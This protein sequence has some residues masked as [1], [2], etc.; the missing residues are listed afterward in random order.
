MHRAI[1]TPRWLLCAVVCTFAPVAGFA[2]ETEK[3]AP[4]TP[5][6]EAPAAIETITAEDLEKH[7]KIVASDAFGGRGTGTEG[8]AKAAAYIAKHFEACGLEPMGDEGEDGKRGWLQK[9]PITLK[10]PTEE[11]GFRN[12]EGELIHQR[13]GWLLS[14]AMS[15]GRGKLD[16]KAPVR[17]LDRARSLEGEDLAE[18]I[19]VA[20]VDQDLSLD[21]KINVMQAMGPGFKEMSRLRAMA[22][23]MRAA[24]AAGGVILCKKLSAPFLAMSGMGVVSRV[25]PSVSMGH[26]GHRGDPMAAMFSPTIPLL[27]LGGADANAALEALGLDPEV[28]WDESSEDRRKSI[29]GPFILKGAPE[30]VKTHAVNVAGVL[31]GKDP[32]LGKQAIVLSAHFDHEGTALDGTVF[33]GADDNGSG[34]VSLLEQVQAF[35]SLKPEERPRRSIV[36]LAVSG[37]EKGLWGSEWYA[38]N[39]PWPL[40]D[41]IANVNMDMVGRS[42]KK[43]PETAIAV[44]PTYRHRAYSTLSREAFRLGKRFGLE[45][46]SADRFYQRSDH[47]NFAKRG[48]PIVFFSDDEH[49][50]YHMPSDTA[51]KIE[52]DKVARLGKLMFLLTYNTANRDEK[53]ETLGRHSDWEGE[54]K[55]R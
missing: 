38:K 15:R 48:V 44:T 45:M 9:Y 40:Q 3:A 51:D 52:F 33:N 34:T 43:V 20:I 8:E 5:Q 24:G 37:E 1:L 12:G 17:F 23:A 30:L 7:L 53:P 14:R 47:Y 13:G 55:R 22:K 11:S 21:G 39:S 32:Q 10:Q 50:D 29:E 18:T 46:R 27:V 42:T 26:A 49:Q 25:R 36:F 2:Q 35:T 31:R 41:T 16:V 54:P 19:P 4:K 6:I 28:I